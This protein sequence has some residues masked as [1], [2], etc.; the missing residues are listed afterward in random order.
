MASPR[1][2]LGEL[3]VEAGAIDSMQLQSALGYQRQWGG[4]LG[5]VLIDRGFITEPKLVATI[6]AQLGVG[7]VQISKLRVDPRAIA[8]IPVALAEQLRVFPLEIRGS[9]KSETLVVAMS[10]PTDLAAIDQ[11]QFRTQKRVQPVLAGDRDIHVAIR[12]H[13]YHEDIPAPPPTNDDGDLAS[14]PHN[15]F[16]SDTHLLGTRED[17][18]IV[19]GLVVWGG[20]E[21]KRTA[22][23]PSTNPFQQPMA[24]TAPAPAVIQTQY[25]PVPAT[26]VMIGGPA[27]GPLRGPTGTPIMVQPVAAF[28]RPSPTSPTPAPVAPLVPVAPPPVASIDPF[29]ELG[30]IQRAPE[31]APPSPATAPPLPFEVTEESGA[32]EWVEPVSTSLGDDDPLGAARRP[33]GEDVEFDSQSPRPAGGEVAWLSRADT[34]DHIAAG[35]LISNAADHAPPTEEGW[36]TPSESAL[37]TLEEE[38]EEVDEDWEAPS[39]A[40]AEGGGSWESGA[41]TTGD[42]QQ[43]PAG[44]VLPADDAEWSGFEGTTTDQAAASWDGETSAGAVPLEASEAG[45][46]GDWFEPGR[47]EAVESPDEGD[48]SWIEPI[49]ATVGQEVQPDAT[50]AIPAPAVDGYEGDTATTAVGVL[51]P[52]GAEEVSADWTTPPEADVAPPAPGETWAVDDQEL[53]T[54]A[55]EGEPA[56]VEAAEVQPDDEAEGGLATDR[57][58]RIVTEQQSYEE[59]EDEGTEMTEPLLRDSRSMVTVVQEETAPQETWAETPAESDGEALLEPGMDPVEEASSAELSAEAE[60]PHD[61]APAESASLH[62]ASQ[63]PADGSLN[64][65]TPGEPAVA[66]GDTPSEAELNASAEGGPATQLPSD[67]GGTSEGAWEGTGAEAGASGDQVAN[68]AAAWASDNEELAESNQEEVN[69]AADWASDSEID[70]APTLAPAEDASV[71]AATEWASHETTGEPPS[72]SVVQAA[73][74]WASDESVAAEVQPPADAVAS[75]AGL[76][77]ASAWASHDDVVEAPVGAET[78]VPVAEGVTVYEPAAESP[79]SA[80]VDVSAASEPAPGVSELSVEP[81]TTAAADAPPLEVAT[82]APAQAGASL[83]DDLPPPGEP[84]PAE[85]P[86][87]DAALAEAVL[88][89]AAFPET[90]L[91]VTAQLEATSGHAPIESGTSSPDIETA[92]EA[93]IPETG[94]ASFGADQEV[95]DSQIEEIIPAGPMTTPTA[96]DLAALAAP[97]LAPDEAQVLEV[98]ARSLT[99]DETAVLRHVPESD[100]QLAPPV[101]PFAEAPPPG[102]PTVGA[103]AARRGW[104]IVGVSN[105]TSNDAVQVVGALIDLLVSRGTLSGDEL[106]AAIRAAQARVRE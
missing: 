90:G 25:A 49:A 2:R 32:S 47:Y 50:E 95:D 3:L 71:S 38:L 97:I 84:R 23:S 22:S 89:E 93:P 75:D 58:D 31:R 14:G 45:E 105:P 21:L 28:G 65:A 41:A 8:M 80:S 37:E 64:E 96:S 59:R 79:A 92:A 12:R 91:S 16:Y 10:D 55:E 42:E 26:G 39:E 106:A 98:E 40:T 51:R 104:D 44:E 53:S 57:T 67:E 66:G 36:A 6:A 82:A 72:D 35:A 103:A 70:G 43:L 94:P 19:P 34:V 87:S 30:P 56:E 4:K 102:A 78:A 48:P 27:Q 76:N 100:P 13:Y 1:K 83:S 7:V 11:L 63:V 77:A 33:T 73:A 61:L 9:E 18:D 20:G 86:F 46:A 29:A 69:A 17:S 85:A 24:G 5:S 99:P 68:A 54:V 74:A 52:E 101:V 81:G 60:N 15:E 88:S 62:E